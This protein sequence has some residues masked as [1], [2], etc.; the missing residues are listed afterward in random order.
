[1]LPSL[2]EAGELGESLAHSD[3]RS[4]SDWTVKT[5][6]QNSISWE[7]LNYE[8]NGRMR[9]VEFALCISYVQ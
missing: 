2:E 9:A 5:S 6:Y 4:H 1:M 3:K 7:M 8:V